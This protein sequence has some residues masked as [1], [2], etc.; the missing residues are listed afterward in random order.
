VTADRL[1]LLVLNWRH[2]NPEGGG[3]EV[4]VESVA[5]S[6]AASRHE[7]TLFC[8]A[9]DNARPARWRDGVRIVRAGTK[10]GVYREG[11]L[12]LRRGDFGELDVVVD[13]QNGVPFFSRLATRVPVVVL[14]H[15]VHR[16]QWRVV[17]GP[18]R[19]R[20]SWTSSPA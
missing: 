10:L 2:R 20:I 18:L 13:V 15:H 1:R 11:W 4:Y 6:L 7:V 14:V 8:A 19:S 17:Y 12:R 3:S 16:E 5:R 9:H